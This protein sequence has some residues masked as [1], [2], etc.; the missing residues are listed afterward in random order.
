MGGVD[1]GGAGAGGARYRLC[2]FVLD[3]ARPAEDRDR[4]A[5]YALRAVKTDI[6]LPLL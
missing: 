4:R 3:A 2:N 5:S 1:R 6:A